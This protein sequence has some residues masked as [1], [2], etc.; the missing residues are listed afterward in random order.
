MPETWLSGE[1]F[2]LEEAKLHQQLQALEHAYLQDRDDHGQLRALLMS[3]QEASLRLALALMRGGGVPQA[4]MTELY[5]AWKSSSD[6]KLKKALRD[7]LLLNSS[8]SGRSFLQKKRPFSS[9]EQ[10][11]RSC[12]DT[13]FDAVAIWRWQTER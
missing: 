8:E 5:L 10:L 2:F 12:R 13:E 9:L 3:G 6:S 7:L 4:L 1:L 11:E